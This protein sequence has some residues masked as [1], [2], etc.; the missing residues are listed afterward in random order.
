MA[1]APT[2]PW[3]P[4]LSAGKAMARGLAFSGLAHVAQREDQ[5][6]KDGEACTHGEAVDKVM[7][8]KPADRANGNPQGKQGD[9][10]LPATQ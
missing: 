4:W 10:M 3:P 6:V 7:P 2:W 1:S 8:N 9:Q 5:T